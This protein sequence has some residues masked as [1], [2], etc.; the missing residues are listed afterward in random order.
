M[1]KLHLS[2]FWPKKQQQKNVL[3]RCWLINIVVHYNVPHLYK[4]FLYSS[5]EGF[6][7]VCV[8]IMVHW[9]TQNPENKQTDSIGP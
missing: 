6:L 3:V 7:I 5:T 4:F 8:T 1:K 2:L 9:K